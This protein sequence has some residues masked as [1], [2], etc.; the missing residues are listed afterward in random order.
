M[1]GPT[2]G[3]GRYATLHTSVSV[4]IFAGKPHGIVWLL[5][6]LVVAFELNQQIVYPFLQYLQ[7]SGTL[8]SPDL[9]A[10]WEGWCVEAHLRGLSYC[11]QLGHDCRSLHQVW[12]PE[13][14]EHTKLKEHKF[15]C[16]QMR[17]SVKCTLLMPQNSTFQILD[18]KPYLTLIELRIGQVRKPKVYNLNVTLFFKK[19]TPGHLGC[20]PVQI[21][22]LTSL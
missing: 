9:S 8:L 13:E 16:Q 1:P 10:V 19:Y 15:R 21:L 14:H 6:I 7:P 4:C 11:C 2:A 5:K 12:A 17:P 22:N 18:Y 20:C 3:P